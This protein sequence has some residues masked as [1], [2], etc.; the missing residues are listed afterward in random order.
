MHMIIPSNGIYQLD[1]L[2]GYGISYRTVSRTIHAGKPVSGTEREEWREHRPL[3]CY[4]CTPAGLDGLSCT[5]E[6]ERGL[7]LSPR[8]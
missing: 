8:R 4:L 3:R 7:V 5:G 6:K 2:L 1:I